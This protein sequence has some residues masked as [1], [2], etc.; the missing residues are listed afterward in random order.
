MSADYGTPRFKGYG[1]YRRG[2]GPDE[3]RVQWIHVVWKGTGGEF[4]GEARWDFDLADLTEMVQLAGQAWHDQP[5][6]EVRFVIEARTRGNPEWQRMWS[7]LADDYGTGV[8]VDEEY[9]QAASAGFRAG[10]SPRLEWRLVRR[11]TLTA[12]EVLKPD[13]AGR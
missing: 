1:H 11:T 13:E 4:A 2:S 9:A 10:G 3:D 6:V 8:G 12:G 7:A 5:A